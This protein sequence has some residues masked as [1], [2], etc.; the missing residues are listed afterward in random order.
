MPFL[1]RLS[2]CVM[3][4]AVLLTTALLAPPAFA[5]T[6]PTNS[7]GT[8][9]GLQGPW[10][11]KDFDD[12][13]G[14][15]LDAAKQAALSAHFRTLRVCADPGNMP[16]SDR[17][18]EGYENK[19]LDVLAKSMGARLSYYWRAY[20]GDIVGQAFGAADE[21]D[22]LIDMPDH[23]QDLL[24]TV[25]IY[26]T[27]YVLVWR[28]D[29]NLNIRSLDDAR[30]KQLRLGVFQISALREALS[31]HGVRTNVQLWPV[32][33]DTEWVPAHQP[34]HQVEQV[35]DGKLDI[36]AAWGPMAGWL[37]TM[38]GA[39]LTIQPTNLMD[40]DVPMEFSLGLGVPKQDVVLKFALDDALKKNHAEIEG[41]LRK[42]GVPLV[43]CPDCIVP[44]NLP[45]HGSYMMQ[46]V[47]QTESKPTHWAVSRAQVDQWLAQGSS[48]DSEFYDAVIANDVDRTDYLLGKGAHVNGLSDLGETAL[49][50]ASRAGCIAMMQLLVRHGAKVDRPDGDGLTP[51][52]G[53]VQRD[54]AAAVKFL[55]AH[56]AAIDK[57]AP[58]GFTPLSLAIEEQQYDAAYVLIEAGANV[59]TPASTHRL[60]PLMVVASELPPESDSMVRIMQQHGPMEIARALLAHKANLN[61]VDADGV[62]ALMIAAAHDNAQMIALLVQAGANPHMKSAAGETARDIAVRNDNLGAVRILDLLVRR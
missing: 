19:I 11:G 42:Y 50:T 26:R 41:I 7:A 4:A 6:H 16:L 55:L 3:P 57:G 1:Q 39:R 21:C 52:M 51:L 43:Q 36:A 56:G 40:N 53:A 28:T 45:A 30:L 24:N 8:S 62:T 12:L 49:T 23:D 29:E 25:P 54:Q 32:A 60:T 9:P 33:S 59:N 20:D 47:A 48:V 5:D 58:R 18:Q 10:T 35:A 13:D 37:N 61:T 2:R 38:K 27:S 22:I 14:A 46:A 17:A 34:W 44:G 15:E 31:N